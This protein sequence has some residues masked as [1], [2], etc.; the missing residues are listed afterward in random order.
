VYTWAD[1]TARETKPFSAITLWIDVP[2][3]VIARIVAVDTRGN[4]STY[5]FSKTVTGKAVPVETFTFTVPKG[6]D[7]VDVRSK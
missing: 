3:R 7:V 5:T 4:T 2:K 6:A 1:T